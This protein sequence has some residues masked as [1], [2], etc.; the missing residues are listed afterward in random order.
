MHACKKLHACSAC[1]KPHLVEPVEERVVGEVDEELRAAAVLGAGVGHAECVLDVGF[2][3]GV[4]VRYR[5]RL[6]APDLRPCVWTCRDNSRSVKGGMST[7]FQEIAC[8]CN[9]SG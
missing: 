1:A 2:P 9:G 6:A 5:A 8:K 7:C 4:L 3:P